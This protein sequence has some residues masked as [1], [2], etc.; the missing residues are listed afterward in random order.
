MGDTRIVCVVGDS[1]SLRCG[2]DSNRFDNG[3]GGWCKTMGHAPHVGGVLI[4][5]WRGEGK[6]VNRFCNSEVNCW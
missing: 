2:R 5:A 3:F 4:C 6:M 1:N